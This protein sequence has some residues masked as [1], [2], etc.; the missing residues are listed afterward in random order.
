VPAL[1][2]PAGVV[3]ARM[4]GGKEPHAKGLEV[5]GSVIL[6]LTLLVFIIVYYYA[7]Y[8]YLSTIW[9]IR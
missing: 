5:P 2:E 1:A 7:Q 8:N 9:T 4:H 6:A 3:A